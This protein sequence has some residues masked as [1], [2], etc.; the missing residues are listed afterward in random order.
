MFSHMY[1]KEVKR[2]VLATEAVQWTAPGRG[3]YY[4]SVVAYNRALEPS[5]VACSD[6]VTID[7]SGPEVMS[8]D[9]KNVRVHPGLVRD[10]ATGEV[11]FVDND[12]KRCKV[13]P[14]EHDSTCL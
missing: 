5:K 8:I 2:T 4:L 1:S 9:I 12:R 7:V 11:W 3:Q 14:D 10:L 6:G 13:D